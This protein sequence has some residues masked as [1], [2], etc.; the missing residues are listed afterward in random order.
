MST[1]LL[2]HAFGLPTGYEYIRTHFEN[3][4]IIFVIREMTESEVENLRSY[5]MGWKE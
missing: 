4:E 5:L 3:G 2:H 1:S